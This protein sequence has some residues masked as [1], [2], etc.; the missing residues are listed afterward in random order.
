MENGKE[1]KNKESVNKDPIWSGPT[2]ASDV[3]SRLALPKKL[4]DY[5]NSQGMDFRFLNATQFRASG[6]Y[7]GRDWR[8]FDVRAAKSLGG[9]TFG[10]N[11]EGVIQ[12]GDLILGIRPKNISAAHKERLA[13][14]NAA[15]SAANVAKTHAKQIKEQIRER[16]M[17]EYTRVE[18]GDDYSKEEGFN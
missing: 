13:K 10:A 12:R 17:G 6:N 7:H 9:E 2:D 3:T 14:K 18:D 4:K 16:G 8:P 11:A 1:K 15:Y 5:L